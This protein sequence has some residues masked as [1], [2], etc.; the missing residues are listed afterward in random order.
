MMIRASSESL[1]T[2]STRNKTTN[3]EPKLEAKH[4]ITI[5][6]SIAAESTMSCFE[7]FGQRESRERSICSL[8]LCHFSSR[9]R[10]SCLER[11]LR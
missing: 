11:P 2:S 7:E 4:Y 8:K 6:L 1:S 5:L 10:H 9:V 3:D